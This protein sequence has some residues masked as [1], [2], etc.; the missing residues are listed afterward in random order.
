[1]LKKDVVIK[2]VWEILDRMLL[3]NINPSELSL[4]LECTLQLNFSW[5]GLPVPERELV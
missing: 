3:E 5:K 2:T 4:F 1:M